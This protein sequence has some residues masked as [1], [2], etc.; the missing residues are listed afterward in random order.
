[1]EGAHL[2]FQRI[3]QLSEE[4]RALDS[5]HE[6]LKGEYAR[7]Q[8]EA[9]KGAVGLTS[10]TPSKYSPC[11]L[12][13]SCTVSPSRR[14]P[15]SAPLPATPVAP[16][17][18]PGVQQL[19]EL[20]RH[21]KRENAEISEREA[22]LKDCI[23]RVE[24]ERN[25]LQQGMTQLRV[26]TSQEL[27]QYRQL[28]ES[29][30]RGDANAVAALV[31]EN[32]RLS[33]ELVVKGN[34]CTRLVLAVSE[35]QK[36]R[37]QVLADMDR[38]SRNLSSVEEAREA[39]VKDVSRVKSESYEVQRSMKREIAELR[40]A[41]EER[42]AELAIRMKKLGDVTEE[43]KQI[44]RLLQMLEG[45]SCELAAGRQDTARVVELR[46][47]CEERGQEIAV[48]TRSLEQAEYA[49]RTAQ[50]ERESDTEQ[51]QR[52]VKELMQE[53]LELRDRVE[54]LMKDQGTKAAT[55]KF[56]LR[57]EEEAKQ[58]KQAL[59]TADLEVQRLQQQVKDVKKALEEET[60]GNQK[61]VH[62][63]R[64]EAKEL[65]KRVQQ[66]QGEQTSKLKADMNAMMLMQ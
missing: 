23:R 5:Q 27:E 2:A 11:G 13:D 29:L 41:V 36:E 58:H 49:L 32:R 51:Y 45:Q 46:R 12:R 50:Q 62:S 54:G 9:D 60:Q 38:L 8:E 16:A 3:A 40:N 18:D 15:L 59:K 39:A 43:A 6:L 63:L 64:E 26:Q 56:C 17:P 57:L 37:E 55:E 25:Q 47:L 10:Y 19:A 34:E 65:R 30:K 44:P 7:M 66:L 48:L 33:E 53:R 20:V 42:N 14:Y 52:H 61:L 21:Y 35:S 28:M 1:M 22:H 24:Q 4:Y 31:E